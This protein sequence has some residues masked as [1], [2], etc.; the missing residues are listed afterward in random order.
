MGN[1]LDEFYHNLLL[2]RGL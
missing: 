2:Y 1:H